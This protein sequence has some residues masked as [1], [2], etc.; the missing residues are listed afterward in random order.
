MLAR[1]SVVYK[2][3]LKSINYENII[4]CSIKKLEPIK[5]ATLWNKGKISSTER[6]L[7]SFDCMK[8]HNNVQPNVI[9][10]FKFSPS[11]S[12]PLSLFNQ[13]IDLL[14]S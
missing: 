3:V 5:A 9:T 11:T 10:I 1:Y 6:L 8:H 12:P 2:P 13:C 7:L 4:K 14:T